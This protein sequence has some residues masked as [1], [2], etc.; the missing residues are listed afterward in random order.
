M[1]FEDL[2][3]NNL[4]PGTTRDSE[5]SGPDE[6][7]EFNVV[8]HFI[9]HF[10][11]SFF[12]S[13]NDHSIQ[14]TKHY[15]VLEANDDSYKAYE[16]LGNIA[17]YTNPKMPQNH[18]IPNFLSKRYIYYSKGVLTTKRHTVKVTP[19]LTIKA[20]LLSESIKQ[21]IYEGCSQGNK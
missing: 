7:I 3:P 5:D 13:N 4:D 8:E 16:G 14:F 6:I 11:S 12:Y 15:E 19:D 2:Q 20:Q 10:S 1:P 9:K 21:L 17:S 18:Y